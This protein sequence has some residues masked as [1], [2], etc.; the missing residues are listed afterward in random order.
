MIAESTIREA[1][2]EPEKTGLLLQACADAVG[3]HTPEEF[4]IRSVHSYDTR[5]HHITRAVIQT[6]IDRTDS[7]RTVE[8]LER[9]MAG[10][11]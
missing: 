8:E 2:T 10:V 9:I 1:L 4:K 3:E 7:P 6:I 11:V 5:N